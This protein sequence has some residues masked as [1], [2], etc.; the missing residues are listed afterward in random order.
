MRNNKG[1]T[2]IELIVVIVILGILGAVGVPKLL[3]N[4]DNA[5]VKTTVT[6]IKL[7]ENILNQ[8]YVETGYVDGTHASPTAAQVTTAVEAKL[9]GK[10]LA[11]LGMSIAADADITV[12]TETTAAVEP[13]TVALTL[14]ASKIRVALANTDLIASLNGSAA[15]PPY[16]SATGKYT[17][18]LK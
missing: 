2:L 8:I 9:Q 11:D 18:N 15:T 17:V 4:V 5:R 6:N 10:T 7:V 3:G 14:N 12:D 16:A 1:F 13:T